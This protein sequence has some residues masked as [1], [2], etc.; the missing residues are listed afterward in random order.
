MSSSGSTGTTPI[1]PTPLPATLPPLDLSKSNLVMMVYRQAVLVIGIT[2]L[3]FFKSP[4]RDTVLFVK[5]P[6]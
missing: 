3:F 1:P 5:S 4:M 6:G 2:C